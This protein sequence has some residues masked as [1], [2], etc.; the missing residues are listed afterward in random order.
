[1]LK[2][3]ELAACVKRFA[4]RN[5]F[6]TSEVYKFGRTPTEGGCDLLQFSDD[7][8]QLGGWKKVSNNH[9]TWVQPTFRVDKDDNA[10]AV[11][12]ENPSSDINLK[13]DFEPAVAASSL[14]KEEHQMWICDLREEMH[15]EDAV[16]ALLLP[17]LP[18]LQRVDLM[19]PHGAKYVERMFERAAQNIKPF[20]SWPSF[21]YLTQILDVWHDKHNGGSSHKLAKYFKLPAIDGVFMHRYGVGSA[22]D[23]SFASLVSAS[24]TV[25]HI[26]LKQCQPLAQELGHMI[27]ACKELKTLIYEKG[28]G[29]IT[30]YAG[31]RTPGVR[32]AMQSA[33]A[34]LEN[35]WLDYQ[36]HVLSGETCWNYDDEGEDGSFDDDISPMSFSGFAKLKHLRIALIFLLGID[37]IN[38]SRAFKL[39][40]HLPPS[41]EILHI[42]H[43]VDGRNDILIEH[44]EEV[45]SLKDTRMPHLKQVIIEAPWDGKPDRWDMGKLLALCEE[46]DVP[47]RAIDRGAME[48][49]EDSDQPMQVERGW[50]MN[51]EIQFAPGTRGLNE[52]VIYKDIELA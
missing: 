21:P 43:C 37:E 51:G 16:L 17:A 39:V 52:A 24:S 1:M 9:K 42:T 19:M 30:Y 3:P 29:H 32:K 50:G 13:N 18:K 6:Q 47:L 10:A 46:N 48:K 25:T 38:Q 15:N 11:D 34:T 12:T 45:L 22:K 35:L 7:A 28:E 14:S 36:S 4:M 5:S 31:F 49:R 44:L 23:P 8:P 26:E 20:D 2:R 27:R 40:D 33:E 41:L